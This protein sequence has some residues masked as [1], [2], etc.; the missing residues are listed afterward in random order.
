MTLA[1]VKHST[2]GRLR[3]LLAAVALVGGL[4]LTFFSGDQAGAA[5]ASDRVDITRV[6]NSANVVKVRVSGYGRS[7]V[8]SVEPTGQARWL[9]RFTPGMWDEV[10]G[11]MPYPGSLYGWQGD[12][13]YKQLACHAIF[14]ASVPGVT[15]WSGGA[16]W[17][18][19]TWRPDVSWPRMYQV[20]DHR[21]NWMW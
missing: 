19:E 15:G 16:T 18:L 17:D 14:S 20:W 12:S 7:L 13:L 9:A 21:C 1:G 10:W 4:G 11:C 8:V 3:G 5:G 2:A 6:C